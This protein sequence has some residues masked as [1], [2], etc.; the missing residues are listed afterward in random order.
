MPG[1]TWQVRQTALEIDL[2]LLKKNYKRLLAR[3]HGGEILALLKG[4]AYGHSH[5]EVARALETL[6]SSARLHGYGVANVEEGIEL[7]REGVRRAIYVLSGIQYYDSDLHR[8]LETVSLVPTISSLNVL[9]QMVATLAKLPGESIAHLKFNSG[10]NRL[11]IEMEEVEECL[12]ILR[13]SPQ[14]RVLGILSHF[15]AG[16]RADAAISKQQ[17]KNFRSIVK[18]FQ[19]AGIRP[20]YVHMENSSGLASGLFPE[21][22]LAR[23][24]IHLYGLDDSTLDPVA[25]WTAQV[26]Q[27]RELKKGDVVG[28][29]PRFRAKKKMKMAV[30]GV[31]YA[32]G[33]RRNF[34]NRA[35]VLLK[36]KRCP[37]IGT[38]SMDLTTVD[39]SAVPSVSPRDSATLLGKDGKER[40]TAEELAEHA[41]SISYEILTGISSRVPR[42]F[43]NG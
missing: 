30:L 6:P 22:N 34:S 14:I 33:Y 20:K 10:M 19:E 11:G 23:I 12:E 27:V 18:R 24:G 16:E 2:G 40:I 38:I 35:H 31:G 7:R 41:K 36:G 4:N 21:G 43:V 39:I 3:T 15:A 25:R 8:C 26:Y 37:V 9:K 29:G 17:V 28:Y 32:D 1:Q 42:V 13:S 5:G